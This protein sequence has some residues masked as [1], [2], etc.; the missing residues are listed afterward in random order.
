MSA[1]GISSIGCWGRGMVNMTE[2]YLYT[3]CISRHSSLTSRAMY[4]ITSR[5]STIGGRPMIRM[6]LFDVMGITEC[7]SHGYGLRMSALAKTRC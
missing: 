3:S 7:L 2:N 1:D 4:N 6:G 5:Y